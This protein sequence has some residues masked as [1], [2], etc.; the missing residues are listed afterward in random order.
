MQTI[1]GVITI[2]CQHHEFGDATFT[3]VFGDAMCKI[4][5]DVV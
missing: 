1:A 2:R 3:S 4:I 5:R